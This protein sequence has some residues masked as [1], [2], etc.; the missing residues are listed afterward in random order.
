[1]CPRHKSFFALLVSGADFKA[2]V[3]EGGCSILVTC[4]FFTWTCRSRPLAWE[5]GRTVEDRETPGRA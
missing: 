1:M 3:G 2:L 5:M 4:A